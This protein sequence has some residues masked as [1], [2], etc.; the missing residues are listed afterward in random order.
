VVAPTTTITP[1]SICGR[2]PSCWA[3]LKRWISST[4]NSVPRPWE[5]RNFAAS[6]TRR[7]SATPV[8]MALICS[9]CISVASASSRAMVV[10]PTPGGPHNISDDSAPAASMPPRGAPGA[11]MWPCPT[12]SVSWR[13]RSRSASGRGADLSAGVWPFAAPGG[14]SNRS[15]ILATYLDLA[16]LALALDLKDK[17]V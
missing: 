7:R 15:G 9:K 17:F 8:K 14:L 16:T 11:R 13:G 10:L 4:N 6:N 3:L 2:K 12:T 1:D 5:W